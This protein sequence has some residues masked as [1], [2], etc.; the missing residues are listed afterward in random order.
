[1]S[2]LSLKQLQKYLDK[3][4]WKNDQTL[5]IT[6]DVVWDGKNCC[7]DILEGHNHRFLFEAIN[8]VMF[9]DVE[10]DMNS[11]MKDRKWLETFDGVKAACTPF[12]MDRVFTFKKFTPLTEDDIKRCTQYFTKKVLGD[13]WLWNLKFNFKDEKPRQNK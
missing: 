7:V 5:S 12:Y 9:E 2:S 6:T 1:M 11:F 4:Y 3:L 10:P 13:N 8:L